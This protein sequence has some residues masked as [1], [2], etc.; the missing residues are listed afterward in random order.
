M[1]FSF[2]F[3]ILR[4]YRG[5]WHRTWSDLLFFSSY[6]SFCQNLNFYTKG[7][8]TLNWT[9][10]LGYN[11]ISSLPA[12]DDFLTLTVVFILKTVYFSRISL[13]LL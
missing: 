2:G 12:V 3:R 6:T 10:I 1:C 9:C 13:D 4:W 11:G 5:V 8:K 7:T